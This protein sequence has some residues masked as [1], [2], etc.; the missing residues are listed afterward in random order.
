MRYNPQLDG[1][2][3]IAALVVLAYHSKVPFFV[4]GFL[5]VDVFFVLSGYLITKLLTEQYR[6]ANKI[7]YYGF[8]SRRL[9]RLYPAFLLFLVFYAVLGPTFFPQYSIEKH[10][11]DI[12]ITGL[13]FADYARTFGV[14]LSV[15]NHTWS[16]SV[17]MHFYLLWPLLLYL[18]LGLSKERLQL[19]LFL[20]WIVSSLWRWYGFYWFE[21]GWYIYNRLDTHCSGLILGAFLTTLRPTKNK[22]VGTAGLVLVL[23]AI[24][25]F[26]WR[27]ES[28]ALVGFSIAEIGTAMIILSPVSWMGNRVLVWLG[29]LSYG[30]YLWHYPAIRFMR[31]LNSSWLD[32]LLVGLLF[33]I[34][35]AA[36][37]YYLIEEPIRKRYRYK[38]RVLPNLSPN[39]KP[40]P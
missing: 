40:P 25:S 1:L 2:R 8:F 35:V 39:S 38:R 10:Y 36:I 21:D 31:D 7:N 26:R 16:L 28:T 33:G 15:I 13:Y 12:V 30:I 14:P 37:S 24:T 4:G 32:T 27:M 5:G 23:F 11:Q 29:K 19:T 3:A 17:E 18:I 20:M 22:L 9:W 34:M 6:E